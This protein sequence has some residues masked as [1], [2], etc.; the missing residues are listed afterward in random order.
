MFLPI[1]PH[2][3]PPTLF[4]SL[5]DLQPLPKPN[6]YSSA[7]NPKPLNPSTFAPPKLKF[8]TPPSGCFGAYR[9]DHPLLWHRDLAEALRPRSLVQKKSVSQDWYRHFK[10]AIVVGLELLGVRASDLMDARF[11][12]EG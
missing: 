1:N 4:L 3:L 5:L 9:R 12:L 2:N 6:A 11:G 8:F 7:A 10:G